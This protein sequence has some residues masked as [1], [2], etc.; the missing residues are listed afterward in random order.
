[1]QDFRELLGDTSADDTPLEQAVRGFERVY[2][3]TQSLEESSRREYLADV[4]QFVRFLEERGAKWPKEV[5]LVH[6]QAFIASFEDRPSARRKVFALKAFFQFLY[7]AG[8]VSQNLA[9]AAIPPPHEQPQP[10]VLTMQECRALLGACAYSIRD[11]ALIELM[12]ATGITL[13]EVVRLGVHDYAV[14]LQGNLGQLVVRG[15]GHKSRTLPLSYDICQALDAWLVI[16]PQIAVPILFVSKFEK[17]L[18]ERSVQHIVHRYL[19]R[20]KIS[21]ASVST[22]RHT[23]AVHQL[24][25]GMDVAVLQHRLGLANHQDAAFYMGVAE[26]ARKRVS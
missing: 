6:L 8:Y 25:Q 26:G 23:Y 19:K 12:L 5:S 16:R 17:P 21:N 14:E 7:L 20:A 24:L 1:M 13:S 2:L 18:G 22:L 9:E 10:R 15:K 3:P 11:R 4:E